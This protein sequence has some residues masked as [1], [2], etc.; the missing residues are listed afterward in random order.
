MGHRRRPHLHRAPADNKRAA[1]GQDAPPPPPSELCTWGP[2]PP[3]P[4]CETVAAA[5]K[6]AVQQQPVDDRHPKRVRLA[7][8]T[9]A[10]PA[11][12]AHQTLPVRPA[13]LHSRHHMPVMRSS[14]G[15]AA[16]TQLGRLSTESGAALSSQQPRSVWQRAAHGRSSMASAD[17]AVARVTPSHSKQAAHNGVCVV[18]PRASTVDAAAEVAA[19]VPPLPKAAGH[20]QAFGSEHRLLGLMRRHGSYAA[21]FTEADYMQPTCPAAELAPL[22]HVDFAAPSA[23]AQELVAAGDVAAD[24]PL[25]ALQEQVFATAFVLMFDHN[26]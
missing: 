14:G 23:N 1:S 12:R 24:L 26:T 20:R 11:D 19:A 17:A 5:G 7:A 13:A 18:N 9:A 22:P 8:E 15:S 21:K 16:G 6:R 10:G 4:V 2:P 3:Q 25:L